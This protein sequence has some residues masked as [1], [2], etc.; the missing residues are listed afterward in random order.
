MM[1]RD[2]LQRQGHR[3]RRPRSSS[4]AGVEAPETDDERN[5]FSAGLFVG[6]L[7]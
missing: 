1:T 3:L 2:E 7:G 5:V 4:R 6:T